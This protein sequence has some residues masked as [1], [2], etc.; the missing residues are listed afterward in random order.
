[1][2]RTIALLS[3]LLFIASA[4][5]LATATEFKRKFNAENEA[6]SSYKNGMV[7]MEFN[8]PKDMCWSYIPNAT[9]LEFQFRVNGD[10][11]D[12]EFDWMGI[13]ITSDGNQLL[14]QGT[15]LS[16]ILWR[17]GDGVNSRVVEEALAWDAAIVKEIHSGSLYDENN[18]PP[19][20]DFR[21]GYGSWITFSMK[22]TGSAWDIKINGVSI[23][24]NRYKNFDK[25]MSRLLENK[26]KI[27]L[28]FFNTGT[29]AVIELKSYKSPVNITTSATTSTTRATNTTGGKTDGQS[30]TNVIS[31]STDKSGNESSA[32]GSDDTTAYVTDTTSSAMASTQ[33]TEEN[34]AGIDDN[35]LSMTLWITISAAVI[36]IIGCGV[37]FLLKKT[38]KI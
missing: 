18:P 9:E 2:K 31:E 27:T 12:P 11:V 22:K 29:P 34:T 19:E 23:V 15:G 7:I 38:G 24:K 16:T 1:M 13:N 20:E 30:T 36:L 4:V 33:T 8:K 6:K 21:F 37:F 32:L 3:T 17:L 35:G 14:G 28:T 10:E 25:D 26:D 5:P